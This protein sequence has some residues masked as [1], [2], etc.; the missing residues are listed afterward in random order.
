MK[1]KKPKW[2]P[3]EP[4]KVAVVPESGAV[5]ARIP[6]AEE[7]ERALIASNGLISYAAEKLQCPVEVVKK[8]IK[9]YKFLKEALNN[10][11]DA[12]L[13][14]AENT[15]LYRV[16]EKRDLIASMFVLKTIGKHRGWVEKAEKAGDS[17]QN[18]VFIKI[19]PVEGV[20]HVNVGSG[21]K[22]RPRKLLAEARV[23]PPVGKT[24]FSSKEKELVGGKV[25]D[26]ID[27]EVIED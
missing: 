9:K 17:A 10:L 13:D 21:K 22:G 2:E 25:Q 19:L 6:S 8:Q 20:G 18:P 11:R 1:E 27:A 14:A 15:M 23:L 26:F 7:V 24:E 12:F 5:P 16:T 3:P 4:G